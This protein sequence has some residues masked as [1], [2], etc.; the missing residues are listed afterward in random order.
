MCKELVRNLIQNKINY[1]T[2]KLIHW[3]QEAYYTYTTT[4]PIMLLEINLLKWF[5]KLELYL[6]KQKYF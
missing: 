5:N 2:L 3:N 6:R 1:K 4:N